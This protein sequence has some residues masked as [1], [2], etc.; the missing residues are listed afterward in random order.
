MTAQRSTCSKDAL[1][2]LPAA[3]PLDINLKT[4]HATPSFFCKLV[5]DVVYWN[6]SR[7]PGKM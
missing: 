4:R 5:D 6:T 7:L 3:I 1:N 2:S